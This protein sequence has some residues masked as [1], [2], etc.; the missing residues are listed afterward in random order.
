MDKTVVN[1]ENSPFSAGNTALSAS[2][3]VPQVSPS[4]STSR[5]L[6]SDQRNS[7]RQQP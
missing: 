7:K 1:V 5:R 2:V 3:G 6:V 4:T